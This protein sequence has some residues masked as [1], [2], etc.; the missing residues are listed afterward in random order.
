MGEEENLGISR[1]TTR[2]LASNS[3]LEAPRN[4]ISHVPTIN[5]LIYGVD[6]EPLSLDELIS[7][8]PGRNAQISDVLAHLGPLNSPTLP[9]FIYGGASTGKTSIVLEI[10]R[11]LKRPFVY[12]SCRTCYSPRILFESILNQLA[13]H[14]RDE[15]NCYSSSKK[16]DKASDFANYVREGLVNVLDILKGKSAKSSSKKCGSEHDSGKMIY[17]I[18]DNLELVREWDKSSTILPFLFGLYRTLGLPEVSIIFISKASPDTYYSGSGYIEPI[19]LYFPGYTERDIREIFLRKEE[20]RKLIVLKI[21]LKVT[22]RVDE[23]SISFRPLYEKYRQPLNEQGSSFSWETKQKR[24]ESKRR[25]YSHLEPHIRRFLNEVFRVSSCDDETK[26]DKAKARTISK[27]LGAH[28]EELDFNLSTSAKYLLISAFLASRNPATLDSSLFDST[29]GLDNRKRKRKSCDKSLEKREQEEQELLMKGPGTFPLERLLAIFQCLTSFADVSV[30]DELQ[31]GDP[32]EKE[33]DQGDLT[34]NVL[35]QVSSLCNANFITKGGSCPLEGS[36]R[37]KSTISEDLALKVA[38]SLKFPLS[39]YMSSNMGAFLSVGAQLLLMKL[40]FLPCNESTSNYV[41]VSN[42]FTS[43]HN[44][45]MK[46]R[47]NLTLMSY[48]QF[49]LRV[50][51]SLLS[52]MPSP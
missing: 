42:M 31:D 45:K 37:Y 39:S 50:Y 4:N 52:G 32:P 24:E 11:Y 35:L 43:G 38:R 34:P 48:D 14:K 29:G 2:S 30:G 23:L 5:D 41:R 10:F 8:F 17:L 19:P 16:C 51:F 1:R 40:I 25:L 28:V 46:S 15:E 7:R 12:S 13:L 22:R 20:D 44:K 36:T 33:A 26:A 18:I 49:E 21:F 27:K 47:C 9:L 3:N 6:D